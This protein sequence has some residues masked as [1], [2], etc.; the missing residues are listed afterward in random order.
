VLKALGSWA[1]VVH[2]FNLS[3]WETETGGFLSSRPA[4]ST[5]WVP[6]QPGL[7]REILSKKKKKKKEKRKRK[8]E[9]LWAYMDLIIVPHLDF[10]PAMLS[11]M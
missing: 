11:Q 8:K 10:I 1:M 7:H 3:T 9:K 5:E 2:V 4:W 6:G